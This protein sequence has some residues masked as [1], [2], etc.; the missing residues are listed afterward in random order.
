MITKWKVSNFKSIR[1]ETEL[2][3]GPLTI[4]A[5]A[6]SSGK[7]T[8][9][10]SILLIAQT[11]ANKVDSRHIVLNGELISLGQFDDLKSNGGDVDQIS[12]KFTCQPL[13]DDAHA[14]PILDGY[15]HFG[16]SP[17][18]FLKEVTC[19]VAFDA[20]SA[21]HQREL[22]QIHPRL[23]F[24]RLSCITNSEDSDSIYI[25]YSDKLLKLFNKRN[26]TKL[27]DK[28]HD[29]FSYFVEEKENHIAD[30]KKGICLAVPVFCQLKHFLPEK[31]EYNVDT[32]KEDANYLKMSLQDTEKWSSRW[33]KKD[34][35]IPEETIIYLQKT[36]KNIIDIDK[37]FND[38]CQQGSL[39]ASKAET[40]TLSMWHKRLRLISR[41]ERLK[42]QQILSEQE[43]LLDSI[44]DAMDKS[45]GESEDRYRM[46]KDEPT[47]LIE[48]SVWYLDDFF[49][50]S[51][52]YLGPLRDT[53]KPLYPL[54]PNADPRDVGL[55]GEHTASILELYKNEEIEY[56]PSAN[57]KSSA[58]DQEMVTETLE[59]A[60]IDWLRYLGVADSVESKD[61]GKLGHELKVALNNS[62]CAH[63]L[64]HVGV[65]VSQVL[66]ILVMCLLAE[67]D[68]TLIF[69]Q[70]E[71]HLH[72]K[73]QTLLG[74]F[75]LSMALCNKQCIVET[76][77]EY[78]IDRL[79]F[80][81]AAASPEDELNSKTKIYFVEKESQD[82]SFREV[83]INE[84]GAIADWPE[85][86][87]DQ[88]QQQAEDIL[89]AATMKRKANRGK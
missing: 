38:K 42:V 57:F 46:T 28:F 69:E 55:R 16:S 87:F 19:E 47:I 48:K 1:K 2:E 83:V 80:R 89:M 67:Y 14:H 78:L 56:I 13:S 39:S 22:L 79:R 23:F 27:P 24:T 9:I 59:V 18:D 49:K 10:Q 44:Y 53:P 36:L 45:S 11:L 12:I 61:R 60:V 40:I 43:D 63:D 21:S 82:S 50:L 34:M 74:D 62:G 30:S 31:I 68:S 32:I 29:R 35:V 7:S 65:G 3:L 26:N 70:P 37:M 66:P 85:G 52:K 64:T 86:F 58:I 8:F 54:N 84:Y 5:G 72:P 33:N 4:F 17:D 6:N 41:S 51:L 73:V 71:L 75:F 81:I 88:S 15:A 20:N 25:Y 76:H 77:S